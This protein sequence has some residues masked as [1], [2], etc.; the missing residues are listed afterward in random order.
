MCYILDFSNWL[1][2]RYN[3]IIAITK[4]EIKMFDQQNHWFVTIQIENRFVNIEMQWIHGPRVCNAWTVF[5]KV[6]CL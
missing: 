3:Q 1:F 5:N 6:R 2:S 4:M